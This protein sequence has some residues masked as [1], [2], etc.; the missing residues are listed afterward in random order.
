[1]ALSKDLLQRSWRA[2]TGNGM[3][4]AGPVWLQWLWSLLFA[5]GVALVFT[6][7]ALATSEDS[8][9]WTSPT[10]WRRT[11][12]LNLLV[13]AVVAAG[14]HLS[15]DVMTGLIGAARWR[16]WP[17]RRRAWVATAIAMGGTAW[18]WP[19]GVWLAGYRLTW[20]D[21][22]G[23]PTNVS[24]SWLIVLVLVSGLHWLYLENRRRIEAAERRAAEARLK[25]L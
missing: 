6:V 2:W 15:F 14:I 12:G 13:S 17:D 1:M 18:S 20:F 3:E 22:G 25:L 23:S 16:A 7:L 5:M 21:G 4:R 9:L 8:G 11:Y 19:L 24:I 10:A